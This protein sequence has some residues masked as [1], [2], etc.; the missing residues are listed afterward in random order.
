MDRRSLLPRLLLF[1]AATYAIASL[2]HFGVLIRGFE[3]DR[4]GTAEAIIAA[5]LLAGL[6]TT[7]LR[8]GWTRSAAFLA[9]LFALIGTFVG[10]FSIVVGF[11]PRTVPDVA[12]H[13]AIVVVLLVGLVVTWR[14]PVGANGL[15][16]E[17]AS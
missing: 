17:A 5:V 2:V 10:L 15:E 7:L 1:E 6:A 9:Q 4:A 14:S 8:P 13:A 16:R 11:G 12:Y 3:H